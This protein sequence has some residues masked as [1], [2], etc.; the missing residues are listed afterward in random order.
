MSMMTP[1]QNEGRKLPPRIHGGRLF[2]PK[3]IIIAAGLLILFLGGGFFAARSYET[4]KVEAGRE[5]IAAKNWDEAVTA[6]DGAIGLQPAFLT[7]HTDEALALRGFS[8]YQLGNDEAALDD[9]GASMSIDN[10]FFD[11]PAYRA[12][13][14][15]RQGA[16]AE[17]LGNINAAL[18]RA[19]ALPLYLQA[20][21]HGQKALALLET[22][23]EEET[24]VSTLLST[25]VSSEIEAA[26]ALA[27]YL[28]DEM[29][30]QLLTVRA[31]SAFAAGDVEAGLADAAQVEA[32][33]DVP[34][35]LLVAVT[36]VLYQQSDFEATVAASDR[37]LATDQLTDDETADLHLLRADI[38]FQQGD[39]E[40]A[41][42]EAESAAAYVD[43]LA[44]PD[45]LQAWQYYRQFEWDKAVDAAEAALALDEETPLA[46]RV[47]GAVAFWQGR[48]DDALVDLSRAL[49]LDPTDVEALA[50]RAVLYFLMSDEEN[51]RADAARAADLT[52]QSP[53]ALW[54]RALVH[55]WDYE[56]DEA[57]ALLTQAIALD[58]QRT[59]LYVWRAETYLYTFQDNERAADIEAALALYPEFAQAISS[60]LWLQL[61]QYDTTEY[62]ET[63]RYLLETYPDWDVSYRIAASY[64][65]RQVDDLDQAMA[66]AEQ[67]V[68][69]NPN[70][71]KNYVV[72]GR[73]WLEMGEMENAIADY[74]RALEI[75]PDSTSAL[76]ALAFRAGDQ[77]EYETAIS[78]MEQAFLLNSSPSTKMALANEYALLGDL[79]KAWEMTHEVLALDPD[80]D[81]ALLTR[82]LL[83]LDAGNPTQALTDLT[84]L[85][86]KYPSFAY[87]YMLRAQLRLEEGN[88]DEARADANR[89]LELDPNG[90]EGAHL[91]LGTVA[92]QEGDLE[93]AVSH[94]D[95]YIA[96][97][98]E[99][100]FKYSILV[101]LYGDLGREED[102]LAAIEAGLALEDEAM[103]ALLLDRA[104]TYLFAEDDENARAALE[105]LFANSTNLD[106]LY[107]AENTLAYLDSLPGLVNGRRLYEDENF[108]LTYSPDWRIEIIDEE[109]FA[110]LLI[111]EGEKWDTV[112]LVGATNGF[113][114]LTT[115]TLADGV[116]SNLSDLSGF[117]TLSLESAVIAGQNG[118]VR[119]YQLDSADKDG[120]DVV[121]LGRQYYLVSGDTIVFMSM[122]AAAEAY[123][124]ISPEWDAI[125]ASFELLP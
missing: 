118:L 114:S 1:E 103:D 47:R 61:D 22:G 96:S 97:G 124:Q 38:A 33:G 74:E 16:Y 23:E 121:I 87:A 64:Y 3:W 51:G 71:S 35:E 40:Q 101:G 42:A 73:V 112:M 29:L 12:D 9:F 37:A 36:A 82:S 107:Q 7:Q 57:Y 62:E 20:Q 2:S 14:L 30:G 28:P 31:L 69:A 44:L 58:D 19:D 95:D 48:Y 56:N 86:N 89:A 66:Y 78:Y 90:V 17:A 104:T 94:I 81:D 68:A 85:I 24:A 60:R 105:E 5:A 88:L 84:V 116:G 75:S 13:I 43:E 115:R 111:Q 65:D 67:A 92:A 41:I 113:T 25:S 70:A 117:Q 46:Y 18:A 49:E 45:A 98:D 59:E 79:D 27:D 110:L 15:Y 53:A 91:I 6:L 26:L 123:E 80:H 39:L 102:A 100:G 34:G 99:T 54:A 52:P 32:L 125:V 72:R 21:L 120:N 50:V 122:E 11:L 93:T 10:R 8:Q 4:Q 109:L 83:W 76:L 55:I 108:T 63:V 119:Y 106:I 77:G